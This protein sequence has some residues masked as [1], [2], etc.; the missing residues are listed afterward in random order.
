MIDIDF[1]KQYNDRFGHV[2]GDEC[3][4]KVAASLTSCAS[5]PRDFLARF[6]GEEFVFV[7]PD[8]DAAGAARIAQKC[9]EAITAADIA[10]E[11]STGARLTLSMGVGTTVPAADDDQVAFIDAVDHCLYE[12][13]ASGRNAVVAKH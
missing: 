1:F 4:K 6:G 13:K 12:A 7:L 5:R 8:T 11:T 9:R 10:H 3:L 2:R